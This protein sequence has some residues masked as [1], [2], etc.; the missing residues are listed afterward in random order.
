MSLIRLEF[1]TVSTTDDSECRANAAHCASLGLPK[2]LHLPKASGALAICGGAPSLQSSLDALRQW[3]GDIWAINGACAWLARRGV[4]ST[5]ITVHP[6]AWKPEELERATEGIT[7]AFLADDCSPALFDALRG[8]DVRTFSTE[9]DCGRNGGSTTASRVP[10]L[11]LKAGYSEMHFFGCEGSFAE[12]SHTY[13]DESGD[14]DVVIEAGGLSYR[15]NCQMMLQ[16][17]NLALLIRAFPNILK[18]RSGGLLAAMVAHPETW[19]V[20][21]DSPAVRAHFGEVAA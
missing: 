13:K 20:R 15:T 17:E 10:M 12:R 21:S 16:S 11:A 2:V 4:F 18:D 1:P 3:D 5:F 8:A 19:G 9:G 14:W 6:G 7:R